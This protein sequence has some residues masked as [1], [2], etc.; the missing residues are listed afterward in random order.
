MKI[1]SNG[2]AV[3]DGDTHHAVWVEECGLVHDQWFAGQITKHLNP[4]DVVVEGGANIGTLTKAMLG[5]G[6]TV[7]A[8]ECNPE[9]V[10]CLLHNCQ[11]ET[12]TVYGGCA[13]GESPDEMVTI[14]REEN[15]GATF[16][17]LGGE[18]PCYTID[19]LGLDSCKLIKLDVE[20]FE[21]RVLRGARE[22]IARC[23]PVLI[24][25]V[26]KSALQRAGESEDSLLSLIESFGYEWRIM[27][28][29]CERGCAQYD[30]VCERK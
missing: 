8:F 10:E 17:T 29:N 18:V 2:A 9:A 20:G 25:E 27:Q 6:A 30:V 28:D 1:L 19:E 3:I 12:L 7:L 26:N 14:H 11:S 13:L 16:A 5:A 21:P 23:R 15:A 4:S 24:V 22:T